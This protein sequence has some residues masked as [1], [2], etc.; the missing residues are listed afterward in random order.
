MEHGVEYEHKVAEENKGSCMEMVTVYNREDITIFACHDI[1]CDDKIIEVKTTEFGH[2]RWYFES[3]LVQ[4]AFYKS[5][6]MTSNGD[7]F[8]P[9]FR[10]REGY[11][12]D[13][14]KAKPDI[15]YHLRFGDEE[16]KIDVIHPE[17]I[18]QYFLNK[19]KVTMLEYDDC[20]KYDKAHKFRHYSDLCQYFV[21][22]RIN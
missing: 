8:T 4:V 19:A 3:S 1:V 9:K 22:E 2:E 13:Y 20:R 16:Y 6:L 10:I 14:K 12:K 17:S 18:I 11:N 7:L 21:S 15:E 5:L